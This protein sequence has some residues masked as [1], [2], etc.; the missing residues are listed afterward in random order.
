MTASLR[1]V[2]AAAAALALLTPAAAGAAGPALASTQT[3]G[4]IST[5][6]GGVGGPA[7]ATKV[8]LANPCGVA[9]GAGYLYVAGSRSVR[10]VNPG[11]GRLTTPAGTG[12]AG[13]LGDGGSATRASLSTC[14]VA[15]DH[16]GN[17]VIADGGHDRIRVTAASS[18][19]FYG[20]A[21]TAGDIYNVAGDGT[22]GFSGDGGPAT[23]A[24][25]AS[26]EGVAVD[27]AGNLVFADDGNSRVR[28]VA[29]S[30]GTFY[31]QAMTAG[32]IYTVAGNG[33]PGFSGD[34]GPA[35][36]AELNGPD[37]V[38]VDSAGNVLIADFDNNRV[39]A[40]AAATG[41]F[42]GQAMTTGDIYTVAGN[43]TPGF[44]GDGGPAVSAELDLPF[45]VATDGAGNLLIADFVN[46]RV[47]VAA[48]STGTFYGRAMTA[49]DV[50][51]VAGNGTAGFSGDGGPAVGAGLFGPEGVAVDSAGNLLIADFDNSRVRVVAASSGTFYGK[52][53]TGGDIYTVAGN[54]TGEFSGD[55]GP[56]VSAELS[57]PE[58]A[59]TDA[60]GNLL[61]AD[62]N[63][64]RVRVAAHTTGTF[65]G[66]AMT[67][68][69]IYTVAGGGGSGL[70]DGGPATKAELNGPDG[71]AVDSA[72]NLLIADA[73]H[74]RIRAVAAATG[75]FYGQAMTAGDIY[76]VAG[77]GISGFSGDGG[78]AVSAELGSLSSVT[79]D[80]AGNLVI[81]DSGNQR[82]RVVAAA[83][84]TF[85]GQA[86]TAGD[87]YTVAG[88]GTA[89]F[90]GDGGPAVSAELHGPGGV[91]VD[92]AGNLLIADTFNHRIRVVAVRSGTFYGR[93]MTAGDIYTVAGDGAFG[94]AGDDGPAVSAEL[95]SPE[96]VAADAAGNLLIAD[97]FNHRIRVAAEAT[98]TFYG[99]AMTV[100]DIYTVAGNG[101]R[102]FSGDGGPATGAELGFPR[103]VT[104]DAAGDLLM[105][106]FGDNRIRVVSG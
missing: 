41:T 6:A 84:G 99:Q 56:A 18:G 90:S 57:S 5:V 27:A 100:G 106:D 69:D 89:A 73:G 47:R 17:L 3:A 12:A 7:K 72:G 102:G 75:T 83:T 9:F 59:A 14:G 101:T 64:G 98:G 19:V 48:A 82:V 67:A 46:N 68:G 22:R 79:T 31:G 85:Y 66:R 91:A 45:G 36:S 105:A 21:M 92:A 103:G 96:G 70:G 51:T 43:G 39:R 95:S 20:K 23:S 62:A 104:A 1:T 61:I 8:A 32:D 25:L 93:A 28:V 33:T 88:N 71:V 26:P 60:A 4:V 81:A 40:V 42:Y 78:P 30:S 94:F 2:V 63:N 38:A 80:A 44:S 52:A 58:G 10:R 55:G 34:G 13:P 74:D 53:M 54:G 97:T 35:V 16:S 15:V 50:Y 29:A 49:G 24:E 87:I 77:N 65:Y 11:T 76:T 37:G 86:M